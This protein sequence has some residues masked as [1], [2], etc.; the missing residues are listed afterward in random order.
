MV[1]HNADDNLPGQQAISRS[2]MDGSGEVTLRSWQVL[3][4]VVCPFLS[5]P[6]LGL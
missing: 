3:R 5:F 2:A 1:G 4:G 6:H